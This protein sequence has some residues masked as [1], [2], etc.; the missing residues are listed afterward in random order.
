MQVAMQRRIIARV[1]EERTSLKPPLFIR[2]IAKYP[3]LSR[4]PARLIGYGV[5][6]EHVRPMLT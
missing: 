2:L 6:P 4:I 3:R 1:L 5:R